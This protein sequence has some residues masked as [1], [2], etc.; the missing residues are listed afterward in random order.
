MFMRFDA[1]PAT[2]SVTK[3]LL[4]GCS[5]A[6][7]ESCRGLVAPGL[8]HAPNGDLR[9][10]LMLPFGPPC[11]NQHTMWLVYARRRAGGSPTGEPG[12]PAG[13][14]LGCDISPGL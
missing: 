13:P 5:E 7:A 1:V 14:A 8:L 11:E 9:L 3:S 2:H 10:P 12:V 6:R 4:S